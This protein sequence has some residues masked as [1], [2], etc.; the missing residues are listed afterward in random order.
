M[1]TNQYA[2]GEPDGLQKFFFEGGMLQVQGAIK[3]GKCEGPVKRYHQNAI[4]ETSVDFKVEK[5]GSA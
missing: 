3:N 1:S 4:L 5:E 2:N